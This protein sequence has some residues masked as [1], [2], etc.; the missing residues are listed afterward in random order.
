[1]ASF[2]R[3]EPLEATSGV[4]GGALPPPVDLAAAGAW[5]QVRRGAGVSPVRAP[6]AGV[7]P[8]ETGACGG[9]FWALAVADSDEEDGI[10]M[11]SILRSSPWTFHRLT[12]HQEDP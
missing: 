2:E 5:I 11:R 1:M 10:L 4:A 3:S 6:G 7:A 12:K 8:P 9:R